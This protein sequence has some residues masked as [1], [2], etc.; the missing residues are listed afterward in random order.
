MVS[1]RLIEAMQY[2]AGWLSYQQNTTALPKPDLPA[3]WYQG[4]NDARIVARKSSPYYLIPATK[5]I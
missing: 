2:N 5:R 4:W 1:L 3:K